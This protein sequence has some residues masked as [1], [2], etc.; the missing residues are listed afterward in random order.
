MKRVIL[1]LIALPILVLS[2]CSKNDNDDIVSID[3]DKDRMEIWFVW[4]GDMSV[5][6]YSNYFMIQ[7]PNGGAVNNTV[8]NMKYVETPDGTRMFVLPEE[9][10]KKEYTF[11]TQLP[12]KYIL[13]QPLVDG[14]GIVE[15]ENLSGFVRFKE[16]NN[17]TSVTAYF[18]NEDQLDFI[19]SFI[20]EVGNPDKIY[21]L[22]KYG[23]RIP[24]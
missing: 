1:F 8:S 16:L 23:I 17:N 3:K 14:H 9:K 10:A 13:L 11:T 20:Y 18:D 22:E 19:A 15:T 12:V 5:R 7:L 2:S 24:K 6:D 4:A 21:E